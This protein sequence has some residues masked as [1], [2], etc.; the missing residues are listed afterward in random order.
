MGKPHSTCFDYIHDRY[1]I[2]PARTLMTGDR[3]DTDILFGNHNKIDTLLVLTGV[4]TLSNV[5]QAEAR[6]ETDL[7]PKF[8]ASSIAVFNEDKK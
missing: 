2:D 7:M 5:L 3:L 8:Y 1:H 4:H 6:A